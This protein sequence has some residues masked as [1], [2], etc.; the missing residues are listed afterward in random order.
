MLCWNSLSGHHQVVLASRPTVRHEDLVVHPNG[1]SEVHIMANHHHMTISTAGHILLIIN[2]MH[3]LLME[4]ILNI[5]LQG[6][7]TVLVGSKGLTRV[8]RG[9]PHIMVDMIIMVDKAV[10]HLKLLH[11]PSIP[12]QSPNMVPVL[13]LYPPWD[14]P[15]LR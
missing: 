3:L 2:H 5:W 9:H 4:I 6:A 8:F 7:V 13:L 15:Q 14:H 1:V 10:I 12:V 11:L